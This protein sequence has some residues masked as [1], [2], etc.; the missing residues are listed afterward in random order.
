MPTAAHAPVTLRSARP[1]DVDTDVL[2]VPV[3]EGESFPSSVPG[4]DD[5]TGGALGR[6][7]ESGEFQ[8]RAYELFLTPLDDRWRATRV[9]LIGAGKAAAFDLERVRKLGT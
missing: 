5:A 9:A 7:G 1:S 4:L 8:G 3:F 6:A 2:F